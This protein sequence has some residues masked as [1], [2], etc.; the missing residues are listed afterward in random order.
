[1]C[2]TVQLS[3]CF[4]FSRGLVVITG[5]V[6]Y[7]ERIIIGNVFIGSLNYVYLLSSAGINGLVC[8]HV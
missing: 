6:K 3:V 1:M 8:H 2:T 7:I 4:V 5:T